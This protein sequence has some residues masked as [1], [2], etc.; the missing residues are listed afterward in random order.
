MIPENIVH[1]GENR[2]HYGVTSPYLLP[3][4]PEMCSKSTW[5]IC[6]M[7]AS[8]VAEASCDTQG[9]KH[10]ECF[11]YFSI[12]KSEKYDTKDSKRSPSSKG[13]K[14]KV[15]DQTRPHPSFPGLGKQFS[16][17]NFLGHLGPTLLFKCPWN[18]W[19]LFFPKEINWPKCSS[20]LT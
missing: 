18:Q 9:L 11:K 6:L 17:S 4:S 13:S 5:T 3:T 14:P 12:S 8:L 2:D 16:L 10:F 15:S 7:Q 20:A 19:G 1:W